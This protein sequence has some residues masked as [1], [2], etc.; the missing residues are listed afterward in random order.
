VQRALYKPLG[1]AAPIM[2]AE[3]AAYIRELLEP[4]VKGVEQDFGLDLRSRWG[5]S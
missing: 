1:D 2:A 4:E 3:D 5:W